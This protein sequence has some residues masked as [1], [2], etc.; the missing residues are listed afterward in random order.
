LNFYAKG[1]GIQIGLGYFEM[2]GAGTLNCS[3]TQG[4]EK[5]INVL[6]QMGGRPLAAKIA[7]GRLNV[8]GVASGIGIVGSP[9]QLLT[10]YTIAGVQAAVGIGAGVQFAAH[11]SQDSITLNGTLQ[12]TSGLGVFAGIDRLSLMSF[13]N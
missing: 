6:V 1:G 9:E 3:D 8:W 2:V 13:D 11:A 4:N 5:Q 7:I 12:A 10:D